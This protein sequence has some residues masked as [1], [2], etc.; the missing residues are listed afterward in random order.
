[1]DGVGNSTFPD[2]FYPQVNPQGFNSDY[3]RFSP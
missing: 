1:M 2:G 3:P